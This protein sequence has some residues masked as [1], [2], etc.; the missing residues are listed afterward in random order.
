MRTYSIAQETLLKTLWWP[1]WEGSKK[2]EVDVMAD[3]LC[4]TAETTM[5]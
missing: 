1:K 2:E 4:H 3:S 5:L